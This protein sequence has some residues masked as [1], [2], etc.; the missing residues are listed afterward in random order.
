MKMA[1][2]RILQINCVYPYGST[3]KLASTIHH[4]LL[5]EG[6]ESMV[7][8]SRGRQRVEPHTLRVSTTLEGKANH[9]ISMLTGDVYGGCGMQTHRL[10]RIIKRYRPDV[11]HLQCINGYFVNIYRLVRFLKEQ[12][13]PTVLTL[14]ADFMFTANCGSAFDCDKWQTGCGACPQLRRAT[15]SL[16]FDRTHRSFEKMKN[17]FEGFESSLTVVGVSDWLGQRAARSP[18]LQDAR[19]ITIHNGI[20]TAVFK[21]RGA[22]VRQKLAIADGEKMILWVTSFFTREKGKDLFF[23]LSDVMK[24][25]GYR[26]VVVGAE[27]PCDYEGPVTFAGLITDQQALAA[28]YSAADVAL[29]C[30]RQESFSL[31]SAE[32]QCCGTPVVGFDA[33]GVSEAVF[34]GMGEVVPLGDI[35][36]MAEAVA[37]WSSLKND[38]SEDTVEACRRYFSASRM[39]EAYISLYRA[40]MGDA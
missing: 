29:C 28:Y 22:D 32:A 15:H 16:F 11:V 12:G 6:H 8:Y 31:V 17:A 26:F 27:K 40:M 3:G 5:D 38:I 10:M 13:L 36:A 4:R 37:R 19:I 24:D 7:L 18:I 21:P 1:D 25:S 39:T 20:D 34:D 33:G 2:M 14:H 9:L 23:E 35:S 30:S